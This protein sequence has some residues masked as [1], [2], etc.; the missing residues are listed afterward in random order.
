M[1]REARM[2]VDKEFKI[3]EID[4]KLYGSFIEHLGRAIYPEYIRDH[5][6]ADEEGFRRML[7]SWLR[8]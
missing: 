6:T 7:L 8:S 1:K 3:D 2:V 5:P 4:D